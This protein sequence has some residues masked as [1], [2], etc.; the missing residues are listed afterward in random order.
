MKK[1]I[2]M[3]IFLLCTILLAIITERGPEIQVDEM[4]L[5]NDDVSEELLTI[6]KLGK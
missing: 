4:L 2:I 5:A 3:F 1:C 6:N